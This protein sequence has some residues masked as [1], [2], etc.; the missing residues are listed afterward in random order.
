MNPLEQT[1]RISKALE[2]LD[3]VETE[4]QE[5]LKEKPDCPPIKASLLYLDSSKQSLENYQ[6]IL[7]QE[8]RKKQNYI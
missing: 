1:A 4:L 8:I 7:Q 3:E 5:V 6:E 2:H